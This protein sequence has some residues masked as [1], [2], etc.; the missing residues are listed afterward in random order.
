VHF[1][2]EKHH[3]LASIVFVL[4][5]YHTYF[6]LFDELSTQAS[7][8]SPLVFTVTLHCGQ[9]CYQFY[10]GTSTVV[11]LL[12]QFALGREGEWRGDAPSAANF[13]VRGAS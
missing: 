2:L 8:L 1:N 5:L 3:L 12:L 10:T 6:A 9:L 7:L 4:G 13:G 11:W